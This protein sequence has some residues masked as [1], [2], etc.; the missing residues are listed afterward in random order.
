MAAHINPAFTAIA[1]VVAI[2]TI[3]YV[4]FWNNFIGSLVG[5]FLRV[6][7]WNQG[8]HSVWIEIGTF[9]WIV[10]EE[11]TLTHLIGSIHFSLVAGRILFKNVK[12]HSSNQTIKIVKGQISWRYWIRSPTDEREFQMRTDGSGGTESL[13]VKFY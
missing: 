11:C 13:A 1:G 9:P 5:F 12:Y 6:A 8:E 10:L 3:A 7:Y 2:A 4:F